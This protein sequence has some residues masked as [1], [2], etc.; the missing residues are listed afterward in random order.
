MPGTSSGMTKGGNAMAL[1]PFEY[2]NWYVRNLFLVAILAAYW[3]LLHFGMATFTGLVCP[4]FAKIGDFAGTFFMALLAVFE[5][6]LVFLM[7]ES[8]L[9]H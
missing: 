4:V 3:T 1:P 8:Y 7:R 6:F 2:F 5:H 9:A